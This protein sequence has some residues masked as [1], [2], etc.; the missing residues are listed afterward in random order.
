MHVSSLIP[1]HDGIHTR[2]NRDAS[3]RQQGSFRDTYPVWK[4]FL[5]LRD[6]CTVELSLDGGSYSAESSA[7]RPTTA[8]LEYCRTAIQVRYLIV[9]HKQGRSAV[10]MADSSF[11]LA[12]Q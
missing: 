2:T 1:V 10:H 12:Q 3:G 6:L 8:N 11:F 7:Y 5:K 9:S 4:A